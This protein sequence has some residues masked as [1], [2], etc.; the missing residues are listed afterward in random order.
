[1]PVCKNCQ[2]TFTGKYCNECGEKAY[3]EH[4]RSLSHVVHEFSHLTLHFDSKIFTS[5]KT[6]FSKPGLLS[7]DFCDGK[8]K[9]YYPPVSLFLVM[10]IL[11]LIFPVFRGLNL[12][13]NYYRDF[14]GR[15]SRQMIEEKMAKEEIQ[16]DRL[17]EKYEKVSE[18]TA[19]I[20]LF[21]VI[22][23]SAI[24]LYLIFYWKRK[25][26]FDSIILSAELNT[27]FIFVI[28]FMI[29]LLI[30]LAFHLFHLPAGNENK[31][32]GDLGASILFYFVVTGL[33]FPAAIHRFYEIGWAKTILAYLVFIVCHAT[34]I[35]V[36]YRYILFHVTMALV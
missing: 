34:I 5:I 28:F 10:V 19:K 8:R 29:P 20:L 4:D 27:T 14:Y 15:A 11:Y 22:P 25:Y 6:I 12:P 16:F 13:L 23:M 3:S 21:L 35:F 7:K 31:F 24:P 32:K 9:K 18:K 26:L 1:M 30:L 36:I 33:F 17:A 2:N